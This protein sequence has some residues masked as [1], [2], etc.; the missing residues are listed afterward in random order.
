MAKFEEPH[1]ETK[2]LYDQAILQ[3]NLDNFINITVLVDN[4]AK[5]IFK[6]NKASDL[7]RHRTGDDVIIVI[8]E[9]FIDLLEA[10]QRAIVVEES[11]AGISYNTETLSLT[12]NKPDVETFSGILRKH[13][14]TTWN[15]IRESIKALYQ[16][17]KDEAD[18][19]KNTKTKGAKGYKTHA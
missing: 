14:F 1:E 17:E 2:T 10:P 16:A 4:K 15:T 5:K 18:K 8:N 12:I 13:T 7:L 9:K 11:L 19:K 3:T 6:V